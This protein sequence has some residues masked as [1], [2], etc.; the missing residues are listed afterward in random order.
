MSAPLPLKHDDSRVHPVCVRTARELI[1]EATRRRL[2]VAADC[3]PRTIDKV[4]L[5]KPVRGA[6]GIRALTVLKDCGIEPLTADAARGGG[7]S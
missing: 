1:D 2:A 3:D 5:G 4:I 6:A 7:Q